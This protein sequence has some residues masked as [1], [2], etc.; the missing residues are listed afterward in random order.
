MRKL[1]VVVKRIRRRVRRDDLIVQN[2]KLRGVV[3]VPILFG[4]N[5]S[6]VWADKTHRQKERLFLFAKSAEVFDRH[7]RSR[8]IEHFVVVQF[9]RS[10]AR[11]AK[12]LFSPVFFGKLFLRSF[13][14]VFCAVRI[15]VGQ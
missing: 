2:R 12:I 4:S 8:P 1:A 13:D 3:H 11:R 14:Q 7:V 15:R 10:R 9:R 5:P 6:E